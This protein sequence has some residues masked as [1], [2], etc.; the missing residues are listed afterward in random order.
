MEVQEGS[1]SFTRWSSWEFI[2]TDCHEVAANYPRSWPCH[3]VYKVPFFPG[4]SLIRLVA[5]REVFFT[6]LHPLHVLP[7]HGAL[8][9]CLNW[10]LQLG[11]CN[12][13]E[14]SMGEEKIYEEERPACFISATLL[15]TFHNN[16]F[17]TK[18]LISMHF[19]LI[20]RASHPYMIKHSCLVPV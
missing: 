17:Q 6:C 19:R 12:A 20:W 16:F 7:V 15:S 9:C 4:S 1:W 3:V 14:L 2:G 11:Y 8:G 18:H 13:W 10:C 5:H